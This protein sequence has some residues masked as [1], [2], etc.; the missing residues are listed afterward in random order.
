MTKIHP[1]DNEKSTGLHK[2]GT[3]SKQFAYRQGLF[4]HKK[5]TGHVD[6][7]SVKVVFD[8]CRKQFSYKPN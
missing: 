7:A 6:N 2:C 4:K 1:S 8:T 5:G 3:C